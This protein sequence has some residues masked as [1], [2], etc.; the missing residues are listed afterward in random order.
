MAPASAPLM[1]WHG[2]VFALVSWWRGTL[3]GRVALFPFFWVDLIEA[4]LHGE[5]PH[6]TGWHRVLII[7]LLISAVPLAWM[8]ASLPAYLRV[9]A[10]LR[11]S[12]DSTARPVPALTRAARM[13]PWASRAP[14]RLPR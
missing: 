10:A 8:L 1:L 9:W 12:E 2:A 14:L 13:V 11:N 7:W 3:Y 5:A 4:E 6:A